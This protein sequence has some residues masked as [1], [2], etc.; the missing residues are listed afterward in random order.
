VDVHEIEKFRDLFSNLNASKFTNATKLA[1]TT[2]WKNLAE[3]MHKSF[4]LADEKTL[5]TYRQWREKFLKFNKDLY[6]AG[7]ESVSSRDVGEE[8]GVLVL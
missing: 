3:H 7:K 4:P 1:N 8:G 2:L 6:T 5:L